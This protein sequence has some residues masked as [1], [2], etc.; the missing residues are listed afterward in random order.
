[1]LPGYTGPKLG[2]KLAQRWT[3]NFTEEQLMRAKAQPSLQTLGSHA[4][5]QSTV[6]AVGGFTASGQFDT[7]KSIIKSSEKGDF[8]VPTKVK[9][10]NIEGG[11]ILIIV[12]VAVH[13]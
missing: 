4:S 7:S 5:A 8:N 13:G 11:G 10:R 6:G 9:I 12:F 1:M 3:A 2:V